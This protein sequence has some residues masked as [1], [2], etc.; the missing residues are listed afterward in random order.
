[1]RI[2]G[3]RA[4]RRIFRP[5]REEVTGRGIILNNEEG[6]CSMY[7]RDEKCIRYTI[8]SVNQWEDKT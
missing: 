6:A 1:L 7:W 3:N 5:E 8:W 4:L 2:F